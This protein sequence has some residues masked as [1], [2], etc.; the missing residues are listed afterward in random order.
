MK[1]HYSKKYDMYA[2]VGWFDEDASDD[3]VELEVAEEVIVVEGGSDDPY[4]HGEVWETEFY[5]EDWMH[6]MGCKIPW[7]QGKYQIIIR[8]VK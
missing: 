3:V 4:R 2:P 1:V 5:D 7:K 8:E 6:S